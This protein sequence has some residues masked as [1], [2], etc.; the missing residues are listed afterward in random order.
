MASDV[1]ISNLALQMLGAERITSLTQDHKNARAC[2]TCYAELRDAELE[3]HPWNFA[4]KRVTL[5]PDSA[6]SDYSTA[7]Y[8][9]AFSWPTDCLR[10]LPPARTNL[11]WT[12][13]NR[14]IRTNE[15]DT[16]DLLY[17]AQ[18]TDPET[19]VPTFRYALAARMAEHMCE[20]ITQSNVKKDYANGQYKHWIRE[21]RRVN[22]IQRLPNESAEDTWVS[23]RR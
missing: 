23:A 7:E 9:Y 16:L 18:I 20:E 15:G 1:S 22:A 6:S 14:K 19:M 17:V 10:P 3:A 5:A 4:R 13:E 2:N 12:M 21:A 11:D 8:A